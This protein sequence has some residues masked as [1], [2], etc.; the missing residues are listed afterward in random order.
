MKK[1][2]FLIV[3][4]LLFWGNSPL[5]AKSLHDAA[6]SDI[7]AAQASPGSVVYNDYVH[8]YPHQLPADY[9]YRTPRV[10]GPKAS[11][12]PAVAYNSAN[13]KEDP[14]GSGNRLRG[15]AVELVRQVITGSREPLVDE[16]RVLV[17]S[18]VNL[19]KMYETSSFGRYFGEQVLHELQRA[20][21][22]VVDVRMMAG[23]EISQ[24][25]GEYVLS[26]DMAELNYVHH[27]DAVLAGTYSVAAD[28]IF[29]NARLL[30]NNSGLLLA[31][32]SVVFALDPVAAA[33]LR[34][35]AAPMRVAPPVAVPVRGR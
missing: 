22:D 20:G 15:Q 21:V 14:A 27:A 7:P 24:G 18:F 30:E 10:F 26:R 4:G 5:L 13:D 9:V 32:A 16:V 2:I 12:S 3:L 17:A 19:N 29:V 31:S 34:D 28:Q 25:H 11:S 1:N 33:M 6:G 35:G 8:N 23:M